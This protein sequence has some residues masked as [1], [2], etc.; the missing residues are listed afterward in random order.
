MVLAYL[1][2]HI[3]IQQT[4]HLLCASMLLVVGVIMMYKT[5][6]LLL[7]VYTIVE[8]IDFNQLHLRLYNYTPDE[9]HG[10]M[11]RNLMEALGQESVPEEVMPELRSE[12]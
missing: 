4:E 6:Y 7:L 2:I 1:F 10:S 11:Q 12:G 9:E 5:Q 3:F 8:K